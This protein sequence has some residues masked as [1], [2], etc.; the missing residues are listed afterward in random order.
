VA[1]NTNIAAEDKKFL[2][3]ISGKHIM[4]E[5]KPNNKEKQ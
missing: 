4:I 2:D 5:K 1:R 3:F